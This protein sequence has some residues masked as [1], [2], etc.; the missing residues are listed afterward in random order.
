MAVKKSTVTN[1]KPPTAK[2]A[3][4]KT[5]APTATKTERVRVLVLGAG[6]SGICAGIQMRKQGIADFII[7]EKADSAGG[8]WRENTY[9][10]IAC[11]V[12]SHLYS[13]SFEL[14]PNWN[15]TYPS[16]QEIRD[17]SERCIDKY[18][19]RSHIR[20]NTAAEEAVFDGKLWR[21]KLASGDQVHA[22][23]LVSGLGGLHC[24]KYADIKKSGAFKGKRFH[25]AEWDNEC[26]LAGKRVAIIGT[27]ASA[28]QVL[29]AI[30][31]KVADVKVFQRRA[32]WVFPR[33]SQEISAQRKQWYSR[34]PW[35]MRLNRWRLWWT[36]DLLGFASL[37]RGSFMNKR[38][39][40]A[41]YKHLAQ[42]VLDAET[43]Q[44]LTPGYAAG[45]KRRCISDDYLSTFNRSNVHLVTTPIEALEQEGIRDQEGDLH[46]VDVIIEAT[47]FQ[48]FNITDCLSVKGLDGQL[49]QL[50]WADK[51]TSFRTTMVPGF[52]NY[53]MLLGPNSGTGHTSALIMIESQVQ[54]ML[55]CL[56]M[57]EKEDIA[58]LDPDPE[59][60]AA[61][62]QRLQKDMERMVFHSG[63]GAWYTDKS[64][65]NFTLWP[66]LAIQFLLELMKPS[67]SEFRTP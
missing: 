38:I 24:P 48:P 17:Y 58:L 14:N 18:N 1:A 54:Y 34:H 62:N 16:G 8:T 67:R 5:Q 47:G 56:N 51:V 22:T 28:V 30:A 41:A 45:C 11:D 26:D 59:L 65:H 7:L 19:L 50:A 36:L 33:L 55:K 2:R 20:F 31:D 64:D 4:G 29:P 44:N 61:Y 21:V 25:T 57:M 23:I 53:F 3:S 63:C 27:G 46:E 52:P 35:L 43:R 37:R 13:Y 42:S 12:P 39:T 66:R 49:L 15:H 6:L 32:A 10:G 40:K 60:T 9:P